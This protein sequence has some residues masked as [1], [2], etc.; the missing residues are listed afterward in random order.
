M[1]LAFVNIYL[2]FCYKKTIALSGHTYKKGNLQIYSIVNQEA[3]YALMH[4]QTSD[5]SFT[6]F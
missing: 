3:M 6:H 5:V 2:S 1:A 4:A